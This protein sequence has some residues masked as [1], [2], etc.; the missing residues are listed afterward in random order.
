MR[1][2]KTA[3]QDRVLAAIGAG[4]YDAPPGRTGVVAALRQLGLEVRV[5][6][7]LHELHPGP[8][9]KAIALAAGGFAI[10]LDRPE[11]GS[12]AI[13]KDPMEP[14]A[15]ATPFQHHADAQTKVRN[16]NSYFT[17]QGPE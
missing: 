2:G 16:T 15:S 12:P 11:E 14:Q 7:P 5:D 8:L 9:R 10:P 4:A 13:G 3:G 6:R 1:D 17:A